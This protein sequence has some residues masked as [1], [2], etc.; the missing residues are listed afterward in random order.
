MTLDVQ[1]NISIAPTG[2]EGTFTYDFPDD[3]GWELGWIH[4]TIP[5]VAGICYDSNT[6][7]PTYKPTDYFVVECTAERLVIGA[8]CIEG[9]PL[10]DWAQCMFWAFVPAE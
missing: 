4:S 7:Q 1:G 3:H 10:T 8:P 5:T 9:T 6:Q 2:R